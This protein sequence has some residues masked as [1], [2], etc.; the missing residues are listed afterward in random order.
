MPSLYSDFVATT[1]SPLID[2]SPCC[3]NNECM[4]DWMNEVPTAWNSCYLNV[5]EK[6]LFSSILTTL[7]ILDVWVLLPQT[8]LLFSVDIDCMSYSLTSSDTNRLELVQTPQ[9]RGSDP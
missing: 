7:L 8:R 9:A 3:S 4:E 2:N 1:L 5:K 6:L